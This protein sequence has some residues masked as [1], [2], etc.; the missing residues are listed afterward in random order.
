M[1]TV[2]LA[3]EVHGT[4]IKANSANPGYTRTDLS[5]NKGTQPVGVGAIEATRLALLD[6][7]GP[8]ERSFSKEGSDPW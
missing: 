2:H 6:E 8:T 1:L 5:D 3:Y 4:K 7:N